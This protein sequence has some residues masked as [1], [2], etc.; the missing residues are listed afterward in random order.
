MEN[1]SYRLIELVR[2]VYAQSMPLDPNVTLEATPDALISWLVQTSAILGT[3]VAVVLVGIGAYKI[4]MSRGDPQVVKEGMEQ[5]SNALLG[6]L[7]ILL[8]ATVI[9]VV[10]QTFGISFF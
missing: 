3:A 4:L 7:L 1:F 2:P 6:F 5:I 10:A 9:N 8:A